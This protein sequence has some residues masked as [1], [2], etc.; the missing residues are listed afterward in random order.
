MQCE[1]ELPNPYIFASLVSAC[2]SSAIPNV[3]KR[4]HARVV[5]TSV[6]S[7]V[8]VGNALV[9]MYEKCGSLVA[10]RKVFDRMP[11][12]DTL[13]WTAIIAAYANR[14]DGKHTLQLFEG[15]IEK[16]IK[17][18]EVTFVS[19]LPACSKQAALTIGKRIHLFI[20]DSG[21]ETNSAVENALIDMYG[22]CGSLEASKC[23]FDK[24]EGRRD[25]V[26]WTTMIAV[27]AQHGQPKA[28]LKL[29]DEMQKEKVPPD[30]VTFVSVLSAC[31]HGGFVKEGC[32]WWLSMN[33]NHQITPIVDH[34][35]C[36]LDLLGRVGKLSDAED[37]LSE[38][39][40]EPTF[41]SWMTLLS[42]CKHL[43]DVERGERAAERAFRLDPHDP[44]PYVMLS[45]IY[46]S[47]GRLDDAMRVLNTMKEKGLR[48]PP[49]ISSIE[50]NGIVH[51]FMVDDSSHP[52]KDEIY[53]ALREL[54]SQM[55]LAGH[56][57]KSSISGSCFEEKEHSHSNHS[58]MLAIAFGLVSTTPRTTLVITK[59]LRACPDCHSATKFISKL[60]S[61]KIVVRDAHRF[62]HIEDGVCSC[63]D[64]W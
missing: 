5:E 34:Y 57:P 10:A 26:S 62:H 52:Q 41:V 1:G 33:H 38:M 23:M 63:G 6:E 45:N 11:E 39:P 54:S 48:K 44:A 56:S 36:M 27:Y 21:Y 61:R 4:I 47:A 58:E 40:I 12:R 28:A 64:Y 32:K 46:Y 13:S 60:T 35:N 19:I 31:S 51:E 53:A 42:A 30:E 20:A 43:V 17:P 18:N 7:D 29:F 55:L 2:A 14:G 24:M 8:S 50:V 37:L 22:K 16:G 3:G 25:V 59:N 9:N 49:G 15:M